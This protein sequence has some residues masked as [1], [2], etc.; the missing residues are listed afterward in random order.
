[1]S[2][3]ACAPRQHRDEHVA[4]HHAFPGRRPLGA[5]R[6]HRPRHHRLRLPE[7]PGGADAD[8][9]D[10]LAARQRQRPAGPGQDRGELP[11]RPLLE[12]RE[13]RPRLP[14]DD[15][16]ERCRPGRR[17]RRLGADDGA[18]RGAR[19]AAG[20]R[21]R[22]REH[23]R[24]PDRDPGARARHPDAAPADR[25]HRAPGRRGDRLGR[26]AERPRADH[27]GRR[28]AA[29]AVAGPRPA[30]RPL[31][32]RG[33]G[34]RAAPGG[35]ALGPGP[36][37]HRAGRHRRRRLDRAGRG[38]RARRHLRLGL[39]RPVARAGAGAHP[40]LRADRRADPAAGRAL[41]RAFPRGGADQ[42]DA[43]R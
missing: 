4:P 5:G 39:R 2:R 37:L 14:R 16:A 28:A 31:S 33:L 15:P 32:R 29:R 19:H 7:G 35:R 1:M 42:F 36:R 3:A 12:D 6:R 27:R 10:R 20:L 43:T 41:G 40:R 22:L 23:H 24:A 13:P 8:R 11:R 18:G 30:A 17:V 26:L 25:A 34:R 21:G 38:A 9:G